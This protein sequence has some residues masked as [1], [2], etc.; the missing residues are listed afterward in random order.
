MFIH[1]QTVRTAHTTLLEGIGPTP[2]LVTPDSAFDRYV[3]GNKQTLS[4]QA[5]RGMEEFKSAGCVAC[6]FGDNFSGPPVPMGEGFYELFPNYLGSEVGW[7]RRLCP[8]V[9]LLTK[10]PSLQFCL[11]SSPIHRIN[12]LFDI[13]RKCRVRP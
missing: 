11:G 1:K 5:L 13:A 3:K 10:R 4:E 12:T 6:H 9:S 8:H 2:P 7:A